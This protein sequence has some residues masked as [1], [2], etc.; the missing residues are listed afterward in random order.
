[1]GSLDPPP[2]SKVVLARSLPFY[3]CVSL[4]F[5]KEIHEKTIEGAGCIADDFEGTDNY[6]QESEGSVRLESWR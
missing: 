5:R 2:P 6:S 1:M 4:L 3:S